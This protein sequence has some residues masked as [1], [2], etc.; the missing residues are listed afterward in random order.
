MNLE[1]NEI[2]KKFDN[3]EVILDVDAQGNVKLIG[4]YKQEVE[5]LAKVKSS[6][7]VESNIFKIAEKIAAQTQTPFDDQAI[8][9]IKK[10]LGIA[11]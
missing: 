1:G 6:L 9:G 5:G 4:S 10:I 8:A 3:G 11:E 2:E 7:E